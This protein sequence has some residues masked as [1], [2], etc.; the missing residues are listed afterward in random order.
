ME[1]V[2][3]P[4]GGRS[5]LRARSGTSAHFGS[6]SVT[7]RRWKTSGRRVSRPGFGPPAPA[8]DGGAGTSDPGRPHRCDIDALVASPGCR[9]D[10]PGFR[11][12]RGHCRERAGVNERK[13]AALRGLSR[14]AVHV[15]KVDDSRQ[16]S[17]R[18][19]GAG[20]L[21]DGRPVSRASSRHRPTDSAGAVGQT[22][23]ALGDRV[24]PA[25]A[26]PRP[27]RAASW[28]R[29]RVRRRPGRRRFACPP[30]AA[31]RHPGRRGT[32]VSSCGPT[33]RARGPRPSSRR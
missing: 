7:P 19:R 15:S 5:P 17:A 13:D 29:R 24:F 8:D 21:A 33:A 27:S 32:L 20:D 9:G 22:A 23:P 31:W 4:S 10:R 30:C 1:H 28:L 12:G 6:R 3:V 11:C 14:D 25:A 2:C 26:P 18:F 16:R